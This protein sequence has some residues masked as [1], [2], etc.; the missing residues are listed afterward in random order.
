MN[1]NSEGRTYI[2]IYVD[3][4]STDSG[5][6]TGISVPFRTHMSVLQTEVVGIILG[7]RIVAESA[8]GGK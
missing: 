2:D 1:D 7:T 5:S 4:S 3:G 6:G 8:I